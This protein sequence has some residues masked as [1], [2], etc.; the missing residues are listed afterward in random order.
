MGRNQRSKLWDETLLAIASKADCQAPCAGGDR[1]VEAADAADVATGEPSGPSRMSSLN[2]P[3][4]T[5]LSTRV[6]KLHSLAGKP[7]KASESLVRAIKAANRHTA[8]LL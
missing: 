1:L 5:D 2:I 3:L 8:V 7:S 4:S 6:D